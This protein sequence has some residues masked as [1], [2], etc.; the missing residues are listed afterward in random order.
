MKTKKLMGD[1][2][3]I[4]AGKLPRATK[5]AARVAVRRQLPRHRRILVHP[6][7]MMVLLCAGVFITGLTYKT[8][9]A[10]VTATVRA[11][12]PSLT[13]GAI[14][15]DPV[16][17]QTFTAVSITVH[18]TCPDNSYVNLY[19]NSVFSGSAWCVSGDFD[20]ETT[21]SAGTNTMQA[22]AYN[23]TDIEGPATKP[24]YVI[25]SPPAL[26]ES[27]ASSGLSEPSAPKPALLST[28]TPST[29]HSSSSAPAAAGQ[30]VV[31][32]V[33]SSDYSA[34]I[35]QAGSG[36]IRDLQIFGDVPPYHVNTDWGDKTAT[37]MTAAN[38]KFRVVHNYHSA[39]YYAVKIQAT[40]ATGYKGFLQM[41]ALINKPGTAIC[42][43]GHSSVTKQIDTG[44]IQGVRH[45]LF[46]IWP[47]YGVV[48]LMVFSFWLGERQEVLK[49]ARAHH[50][51]T[52]HHT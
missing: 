30:N 11:A 50:F 41:A 22:Q 7:T 8:L 23:V 42:S 38:Q 2:S 52:R 43:V 15:T 40:G 16:E 49:L 20:I 24:V 21:L 29:S 33:P 26:P 39:G 13:E 17:G 27:P 3:R 36:F 25:Y 28:A 9:A 37:V 44:L 1:G 46:L 5:R 18:G 32:L 10:S 45:W 31:P 34:H 47:S 6:I 4:P 12:A 35:C 48:T 14:I 51:S 19:R